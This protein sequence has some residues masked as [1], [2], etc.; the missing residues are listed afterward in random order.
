MSMEG[1]IGNQGEI[2]WVVDSGASHHLICD[3]DLLMNKKET[4]VE[5]MM[6]NGEKL[7]VTSTGTVEIETEVN[8]MKVQGTITNVQHS[9][10]VSVNIL[11]Y[12]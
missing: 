6:P 7:L 3:E 2:V 1:T 10:N 9:P 4:N 8:G 12:G 5:S 11:S